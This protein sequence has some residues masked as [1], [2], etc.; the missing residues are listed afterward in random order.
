MSDFKNTLGQPIGFPVPN[1]MPCPEPLRVALQGTYCRIEPLNTDRHA[2]D[3]FAANQRD[4]ENHMWTYM[5]YGPFSNEVDYREWVDA[6]RQSD[7]PL[8]FAIIDEQSGKAVG[9]ASYLRIDPAN[10]VIEVGNIAYSP[11]LKQT[12]GGTEAMY[13]MMKHVFQTMGYRRYE[14]KC[15]SLNAPSRSAAARFGFQFEGIFR[16]A[17]VYKNRNRDTAWYAITDQDW[18]MID[19]AFQNWLSADN[20]DANDNQMSSLNSFMPASPTSEAQ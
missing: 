17:V 16:Q 20:R 18:P 2:G 10:G 19:Q 9:V 1:W 12:S 8:F 15:D 6:A 7:D 13:L 4:L 3:L 11:L 14:W 5:G